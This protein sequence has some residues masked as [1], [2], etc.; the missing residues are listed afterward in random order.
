MAA[1]STGV[2]WNLNTILFCVSIMAMNIEHFFIY[3]LAISIS[4]SEDYLFNLF[5]HLLLG[6][7]FLWCL[8]F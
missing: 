1:I 2:S 8:I 3:L 4:S 7:L 6:Q 5:A